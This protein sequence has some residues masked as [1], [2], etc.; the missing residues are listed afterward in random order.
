MATTGTPLLRLR[1]PAAGLAL[2][3]KRL[4]PGLDWTW[5]RGEHWGLVGPNGSGKSILVRLLA[6][7]FFAPE[8]D[9]ALAP[10][11][12]DDP[13]R[14]VAVVSLERQARLLR[15]MDAYVQMRW[16]ASEEEATPT[17]GAWL[18]QDAVEE[19]APFERVERTAA[20]V[21]AFARRRAAAVSEMRLGALLE[22]HLVALSNGEMR[23]AMLARALLA[24]TPLLAFD[25]PFVGLD[26][27]SRALLAASIGRLCGR[28]R[29]AVLVAT[30]RPEDLP[31]GITHAIE[32]G[33]DGRIVR[34]GKVERV[35]GVERVEEVEGVERVKGKGK[36]CFPKTRKPENPTTRKSG[37]PKT[38]K[39]GNPKSREPDN[40]ESVPTVWKVSGA[41]G[42]GRAIV[43]MRG[44]T[45]SYGDHIVF[46]NLD[47]TVRAGE[48]W[49]L[50]GP[51]GSGKTTLLALVIGDHPQAYA[52]D[53]AIFG[54]R[55]G[56]G[57]SIWDVKRRIGWV[58]PEL[59]ACLDRGA[60]ALQTVLSGFT[61]TPLYHGE[62]SPARRRAALAALARF[63]LAE[64]ADTPFGAL[65]A[66]EGRLALLARAVVKKPPLL[67]LDEPCQNLDAAN[68]V[69][70]TRYVDRLCAEN[71]ATALLY[72]THRAD[73]VPR[74]IDHRIEASR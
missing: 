12:G 49:L 5:R 36:S 27:E 67:V 63:G 26:A 1:L 48:H 60:T 70:F 41:P 43:R 32:L 65:S 64:R 54:R 17:L 25:A 55:R 21:R 24:A 72:V 28:P 16:N 61:D 29:P 4:F 57:D 47:W 45:V 33:K 13:G 39:F 73:S 6:G 59:H 8:A 44:A 51:N 2:G 19:V 40:P 31:R 42:A 50:S 37:N 52:N 20:S 11:L 9:L 46:E 7:D 14:A 74:C 56:T 35:E 53:V 68:R 22:R 58:S 3:G 69:R 38:R 10:S 66:G 34:I 71:P 30:S 23:R 62:P 18:S 15:A